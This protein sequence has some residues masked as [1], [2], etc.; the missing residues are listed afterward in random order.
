V[1]KNEQ[2]WFVE[3]RGRA[4]AVMHLTRRDDLTVTEA[5]GDLG[6]D[7]L[8]LIARGHEKP[9]ARQFGVVL[10]A[11]R[12]PVSEKQRTKVLR[13]A[14]QSVVRAGEF[15]YPVCLLYFTMENNQG[16]Y[17]WVVEPLL[18]EERKPR[19]RLH[20]DPSC[21]ELDREALDRIVTRVDAWYDALFA[22][23][24]VPA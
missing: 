7:Y 9:S 21:E 17:A 18:T 11:A 6:L 4:L 3:E 15:P 8:V 5:G 2:E 1:S 22:S 12:G 16:C 20:S 24:V 14:M 23:I 10:K 13:T 19:L